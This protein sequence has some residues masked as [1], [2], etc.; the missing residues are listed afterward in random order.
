[1]PSDHR[2][3]DRKHSDVKKSKVH[4]TYAFTVNANSSDKKKA[5]IIEKAHKPH[6][7]QKESSIQLGF[8]YCSNSKAWMTVSLCQEWIL[9]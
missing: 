2:L 3:T 7:F 8:Y 4:L 1:M 6:S 9:Q 5:F